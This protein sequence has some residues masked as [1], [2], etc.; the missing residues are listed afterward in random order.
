MSGHSKALV[1]KRRKR[2]RQKHN[3]E[4][5]LAHKREALA[6]VATISPGAAIGVFCGNQADKQGKVIVP[7]GRN[8]SS[9]ASDGAR[10]VLSAALANR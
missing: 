9:A 1:D 2:K 5:A 10:P 6:G 4:K 3:A 8:A 7:A